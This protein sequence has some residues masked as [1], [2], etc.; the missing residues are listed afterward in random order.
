MSIL[1]KFIG[2][3]WNQDLFASKYHQKLSVS[4]N[5]PGANESYGSLAPIEVHEI[6]PDDMSDYAIDDSDND[7]E[8]FPKLEM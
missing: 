1:T 7:G 5:S 3:L 2:F 4:T 8:I 6:H